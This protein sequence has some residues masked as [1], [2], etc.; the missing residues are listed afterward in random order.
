M[1][2]VLMLSDDV[3]LGEND[4]IMGGRIRKNHQMPQRQMH[5]GS[6]LPKLMQNLKLFDQS[7]MVKKG[8]SMQKPN[9]KKPI[10]F[11]I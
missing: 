3:L 2:S 9:L 7:A 8:G 4:L 6:A 11:I 1:E 10:K 5:G